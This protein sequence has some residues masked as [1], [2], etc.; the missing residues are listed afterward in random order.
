MVGLFLY[1]WQR[2]TVIDLKPRMLNKKTVVL[3]GLAR[4]GTNI[5]WNILQSHPNIVSPVYETNKIIGGRSYLALIAPIF[6]N[7]RYA[8][9]NT[10]FSKYINNRFSHYKLKN[11]KNEDNKY[12]T[13]TLT[14]SRNEILNAT[15]CIKGVCSK[16]NWDLDYSELLY[17]SFPEVYFIS[18]IRN[19]YAI[20]EGWKRRGVTPKET[21]YLYAKY[22]EQIIHDAEYFPHYKIVSFEEVL[23][24]PFGAAQALFSFIQEEPYVLDKLR[25]KVKNTLHQNEHKAHYGE[26]N[27]KYWF[28][29]ESISE[30][31]RY[32]INQVQHN[33][34]SHE[35]KAQFEE[36]AR[37]A[38]RYFNYLEEEQR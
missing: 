30:I 37:D 18:L 25:I 29:R 7:K 27:K 24:S 3:N 31:I 12:K 14:Y 23:S 5:T 17:K 28:S 10:L 26:L 2:L 20:C 11:L 36:E 34:L 19:G 22:A 35:D 15:L 33:G 13:E 1:Q 32:D 6:K 21:G 9:I 16:N 8:Q 4:G 38:L